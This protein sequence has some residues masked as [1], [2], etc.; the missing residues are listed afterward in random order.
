MFASY[1]G[2]VVTTQESRESQRSFA[3]IERKAHVIIEYLSEMFIYLR[4]WQARAWI[5]TNMGAAS[6]CIAAII[7]LLPSGPKRPSHLHLSPTKLEAGTHEV[8][9]LCGMACRWY[10]PTARATAVF[11]MLDTWFRLLCMHLSR[12]VYRLLSIVYHLSSK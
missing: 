1:R 6:T 9:C 7:K 5:R 4:T 2:E 3:N 11:L 12:M 10:L 8:T